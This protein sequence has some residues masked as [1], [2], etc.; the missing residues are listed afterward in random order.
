VGVERP[1]EAGGP[2]GA[3]EEETPDSAPSTVRPSFDVER[4]AAESGRRAS[5]PTITD[6]VATE[7]ARLASVLMDSAPPAS[8]ASAIRISFG[9]SAPPMPLV[10]I[11]PR[12]AAA[13]GDVA[14]LRAKLA[15]LTRVPSLVGAITPASKV[16]DPK[17]AYVLGF[18]DGLLPLETIVEVVGLPEIDTLRILDRAIED[19]IIVL[20][21]MSD[22]GG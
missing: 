8:G 13:D 11:A 15:P 10:P 7:Q 9:A 3:G 18:I 12:P 16:D 17:T 5:M 6:E 2:G 19:G 21:R 14:A 1:S 4:Y 22:P 20:A